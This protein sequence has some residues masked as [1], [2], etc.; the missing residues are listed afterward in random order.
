MGDPTSLIILSFCNIQTTLQMSLTSVEWKYN[1][2][3]F[4]SQTKVL[5]VHC[6]VY[7]VA[8]KK[9]TLQWIIQYCRNLR[10]I[11][12]RWCVFPTAILVDLIRIS[13]F[14]E[15]YISS[16]GEKSVFEAI[17]EMCPH[18]KGIGIL[19]CNLPI[20]TLFK[21]KSLIA[22][23]LGNHTTYLDIDRQSLLN[24]L[25]RNSNLQIVHILGFTNS[26]TLL[27][28]LNPDK[29]KS[30]SA[31][32]EQNP[33]TIE[34]VH[35]LKRFTKLENINFGQSAYSDSFQALKVLTRNHPQLQSLSFYSHLVRSEL[36]VISRITDSSFF[37]CLEIL[38]CRIK[39]PTREAYSTLTHNR[40]ELV[41]Y[42]YE[43]ERPAPYNWCYPVFDLWFL[44]KKYRLYTHKQW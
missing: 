3:R 22:L 6:H 10:V 15:I 24:I 1:V 26:F 30:F 23:E 20:S 37:P 29:L 39:P 40:T 18:I 27:E 25:S 11:D 36:L 34:K 16:Y 8:H 31:P 9:E 21:F 19:H 2:E 17:Y 41:I 14:L 43:K 35:L 12:I 33:I 28:A 32:Y 7:A 5:V 4:W 42:D 38:G 13:P 44:M